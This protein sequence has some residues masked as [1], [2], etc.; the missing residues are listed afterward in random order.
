MDVDEVNVENSELDATLC[1]SIVEIIR[2]TI[3]ATGYK[4]TSNEDFLK[5]CRKVVKD[6]SD[7][8]VKP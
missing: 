5:I 7:D 2:A 6:S 8:N 3:K 4:L 1:R